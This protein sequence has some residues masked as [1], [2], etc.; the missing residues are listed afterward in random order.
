MCFCML[1]F[2]NTAIAQQGLS[3][4]E[5]PV[6]ELEEKGQLLEFFNCGKQNFGCIVAREN[7]FTGIYTYKMYLFNKN[8][9]LISKEELDLKRYG[10]R[11]QYETIINIGESVYLISSYDNIKK[12][13]KF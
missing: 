2:A 5:G 6:I 11:M 1:C 13:K 10:N 12:K 7:K 4:E 9:E 8:L 3:I